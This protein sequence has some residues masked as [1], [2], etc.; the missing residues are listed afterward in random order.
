MHAFYIR[1]FLV[2]LASFGAIYGAYSSQQ[3]SE[4]AELDLESILHVTCRIL[5]ITGLKT[6]LRF[7]SQTTISGRLCCW[8]CQEF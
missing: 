6:L 7:A 3:L 8:A 4:I 5:N 2:L 1:E